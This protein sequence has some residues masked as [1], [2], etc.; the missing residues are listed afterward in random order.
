MIPSNCIQHLSNPFVKINIMSGL[1]TWSLLVDKLFVSQTC[2]FFESYQII[3][4]VG[5]VY[6]SQREMKQFAE[7]S[8]II[9]PYFL[10]IS[11][12]CF[13]VLFKMASEVRFN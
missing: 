7:N 5:T 13:L 6:D 9:I 12:D 11:S 1:G 2:Y 8:L 4:K 3:C 10:F